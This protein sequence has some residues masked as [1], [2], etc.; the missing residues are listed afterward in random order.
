M[1]NQAMQ[2]TESPTPFLR[3]DAQLCFA[4][5]SATL[6][7]NK[8]YRPLL[9]RLGL[10][11][12]QYLVLLVLWQDDGL[13]VSAIGE[14]LFLDSATLTPLLKRLERAGLVERVRSRQDERQVIISLTDA[15]KKLRSEAEFVPNAVFRATG[16]TQDEART[17][18]LNNLER[19]R[20]SLG[21]LA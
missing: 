9:R 18:K 15:G 4:L 7:M 5:Y 6:A 8:A 1:Y 17:L 11:Y 20:L 19:M 10:S 2:S 13:A 12:P 16:C 14:R 3:L 21:A